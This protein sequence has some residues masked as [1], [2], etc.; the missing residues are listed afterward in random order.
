MWHAE[1]L[2]SGHISELL[3]GIKKDSRH[4]CQIL[5]HFTTH[6]SALY[7]EEIQE[8]ILSHDSLVYLKTHFINVI[9]DQVTWTHIMAYYKHCVA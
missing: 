1:E 7:C 6:F 3:Y 8:P 4:P 5:F 2:Q 9:S